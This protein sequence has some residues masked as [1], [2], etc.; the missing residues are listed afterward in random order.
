MKKK[1]KTQVVSFLAAANRETERIDEALNSL[2]ESGWQVDGVELRGE[3]GFD[4]FIVASKE[5][6]E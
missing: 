4:V 2:E 1:W 3:K 5:E 6:T